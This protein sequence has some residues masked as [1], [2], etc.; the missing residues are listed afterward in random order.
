LLRAGD[1]PGF[2]A[3]LNESHESSKR[4]FEN[5]TP[6]LDQLVAMAQSLPGVIGARLTGGGFGG[7]TITLCERDKASEIAA[8]LRA[9]YSYAKGKN[10]RVIVSAIANGALV[11]QRA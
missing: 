5:S 8:E 11:L 2:G 3:L 9:R 6:E 1:A 7:A 4:N 10:P